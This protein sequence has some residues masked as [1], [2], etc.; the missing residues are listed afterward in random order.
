MVLVPIL[1]Y[2]MAQLIVSAWIAP[3]LARRG[4]G[5]A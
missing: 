2:H 4:D 3:G 5:I 1:I